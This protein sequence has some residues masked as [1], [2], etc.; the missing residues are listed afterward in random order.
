MVKKISGTKGLTAPATPGAA[1]V[2]SPKPVE[3]TKVASISQVTAASQQ[4]RVG[5]VR[6][7]TRPMT[8]AE[9]EHLFRLIHEE[10]D[11]M[12]GANGLP[13]SQRNTLEGAVRMTVDATLLEDG[14][15]ETKEE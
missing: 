3:A 8:A 12:F 9:R 15:D 4:A 10:A 5:K 13:E 1:A 7:P 14:S 2:Q 11:K 6:R